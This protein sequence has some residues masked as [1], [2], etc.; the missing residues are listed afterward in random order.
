[1]TDTV[2]TPE[3]HEN[4]LRHGYL[5]LQ[6]AVDPETCSRA[7]DV[8]ESQSYVGVPGDA[9]YQPVEHPAVANCI[10]D[11]L[12]TAI[13]ELFGSSYP[14][15]D[16]RA[17]SDMPRARQREEPWTTQTLHI[18]DNYPTVMPNG[19]ALGTF[20]FLTRVV[21]HGGAFLC[22]AGSPY[23][24]RELQVANLEWDEVDQARP[25][26]A[27]AAREL[28][29]DPG[30]A[31]LFHHSLVHAGSANVTNDETRHAL[32][33]RWHPYR[34]IVPGHRPF[35]SM[36][37][38]EKANS[39]SYWN[40]RRNPPTSSRTPPA[41]IDTFRASDTV[42]THAAAHAQG[43]TH[44]FYVE[45]KSP[46]AIRHVHSADWLDWREA[47]T[48]HVEHPIASI[49]LFRRNSNNILVVGTIG[50]ADTTIVLMSPDLR[51]WTEVARLGGSLAA[52]AL[53][54]TDYGSGTAR[55]DI[56]VYAD[57]TEP[58]VL[59]AR[60]GKDWREAALWTESTQVARLAS[61]NIR[62]AFV[63]PVLGEEAFAIIVEGVDRLRPERRTLYY[64]LSPDCVQ[65][66]TQLLP[67]PS[68]SPAPPNR[69]RVYGRARNFWLVT[70]FQSEDDS[71]LQWGLIDWE[72][73]EIVIRTIT[74]TAELHD[75]FRV[76]GLL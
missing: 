39:T 36:T 20:V 18:D 9:S 2:L 12:V 13:G 46:S 67:L 63:R 25:E 55:D 17:G 4:F 64:S 52:S 72:L 5:V 57:S 61:Y 44:C 27:G 38:I 26:A 11:R 68:T 65:F 19:W 1:M 42:I 49:A 74:S 8:L 66:G 59:R 53:Y 70:F 21:S 47:E 35:D 29:V 56:L 54:C 62:D 28:L 60:W 30:D 6:Q 43:S 23:R 76:I 40:S 51:Q 45:D 50:A 75:A 22:C 10:S 33:S 73:G 71:L 34:R 41:L 16:R 15:P 31:L 48:I 32:L 24:I 7:V 3:D 58:S 69:L 37:T 14:F